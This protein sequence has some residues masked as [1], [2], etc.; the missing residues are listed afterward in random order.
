MI[1]FFD[2][3]SGN[4][5]SA[6]Q[7]VAS[8]DGPSDGTRQTD[9]GRVLEGIADSAETGRAFVNAFRDTSSGG[10][11]G[12]TPVQVAQGE[13]GPFLGLNLNEP[14]GKLALVALLVAGWFL[15]KSFRR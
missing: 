10:K 14:L 3:F 9:I 1:D 2:T 5:R 12:Q 15:F 4:I 13:G 7:G 11:A 6:E 8:K